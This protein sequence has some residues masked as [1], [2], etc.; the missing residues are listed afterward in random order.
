MTTRAKAQ[1]FPRETTAGDID[2]NFEADIFVS[3]NAN[4]TDDGKA[5]IYDWVSESV[6]ATVGSTIQ[7]TTETGSVEIEVGAIVE[8]GVLDFG[9]PSI[10]LPPSE[11]EELPLIGPRKPGMLV[12]IEDGADSA[13]LSDDIRL[14]LKEQYVWGV[15]DQNRIK[16]ISNSQADGVPL[17][18]ALTRYL[19]SDGEALYVVP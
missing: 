16:D 19:A 10:M 6:G 17:G 9:A 7:L 1:N 5:A 8:S 14:A 12:D 13:Q 2:T 15:A 4:V 11:S 3:A 18:L